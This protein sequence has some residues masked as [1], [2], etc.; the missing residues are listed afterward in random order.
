[1]TDRRACGGACGYSTG[2]RPPPWR[3]SAIVLAALLSLPG[4]KQLVRP[5]APARATQVTPFSIGTPD[6]PFPGGWHI[7]AATKFRK[8][9]TY[10]LVD[11]GGMTVVEGTADD[12]ASGLVEFLDIDPWERPILTWRW[13]ITQPVEG[14]DTTQRWGDDAP[15]RIIALFLGR[16]GKPALLRP[17]VVQPGEAHQRHRDPLRHPGVCL[18]RRR[19]EGDGGDQQLHPAHPYAAGARTA[20]SR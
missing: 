4:C 16:R 7:E 10:R 19:A 3:A 8:P 12:S 17:P 6:G 15:A 1:M 11:N 14:A 5:P 13:K 20:R 9:S 18:G 2:T